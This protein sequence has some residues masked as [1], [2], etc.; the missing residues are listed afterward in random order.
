[1]EK[2]SCINNYAGDRQSYFGKRD[3][4]CYVSVDTVAYVNVSHPQAHYGCTAL[5]I[6][7][8]H[9]Q[10]LLSLPCNQLSVKP[11]RKF[12]LVCE[13]KRKEEKPKPIIAPISNSKDEIGVCENGWVYIDGGCY[14][15]IPSPQVVVSDYYDIC[16]GRLAPSLRE[17]SIVLQYAIQW[18]STFI[19]S[20]IIGDPEFRFCNNVT[21]ITMNP[22]NRNYING[23]GRIDCVAPSNFNDSLRLLCYAEPN[24]ITKN[25]CGPGMFQCHG[26]S[27]ILDVL[28]CDGT[29]NCPH[30]EDEM[31]DCQPRN[32]SY[33]VRNDVV[34]FQMFTEKCVPPYIMCPSE[35]CIHTGQVCDGHRDCSDGSDEMA[36]YQLEKAN[37]SLLDHE[38]PN[39]NNQVKPEILRLPERVRYCHDHGQAA[40]R[41][42][43]TQCYPYHRLC[44]FDRSHSALLYCHDGGHLHND[45]CS[46]H[47]C[48]EAF[49]CPG[50]YCVPHHRVC[51]GFPDC[52]GQ[53]DETQCGVRKFRPCPGLLRCQGEER[54][55]HP[56]YYN[57]G[58]KQCKYGDD[59]AVTFVCPVGCQCFTKGVFCDNTPSEELLRIKPSPPVLSLKST[60]LTL[61]NV[62]YH[63][64]ERTSRLVLSGGSLDRL[65]QP[66]FL[67]HLVILDLSNNSLHYV[68]R[69]FFLYLP[70]LFLLNLADNQL[71]KMNSL[72]HVCQLTY[73]NLRS[74]KLNYFESHCACSLS[75]VK[76]VDVVRN[77]IAYINLLSSNIS[78]HVVTDKPE[79]C[80]QL[81]VVSNCYW[82]GM[83]ASVEACTYLLG[84]IFTRIVV[85][86]CAIVGT[87]SNAYV[88]YW[89]VRYKI[90][91][92]ITRLQIVFLSAANLLIEAY[93]IILIVQ[94][95]NSANLF[96]FNEIGW[97]NGIWCHLG[98]FLLYFGF[99]TTVVVK[100][101]IVLDR[102]ILLRHAVRRI[103]FSK[104]QNI[105]ALVSSV[106]AICAVIM[107]QFILIFTEIYRDINAEY[108]SMVCIPFLFINRNTLAIA[109]HGALF[110]F[111]N[112]VLFTGTAVCYGLSMCKVLKSTDKA[113]AM[114]TLTDIG[115]QGRTNKMLAKSTIGLLLSVAGWLVICLM[116][117][118]MVS[119]D[120]VSV[121]YMSRETYEYLALILLL[122]NP[123]AD[124]IIFT[125]S[126]NNY[127][128]WLSLKS[129]K[130]N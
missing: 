19:F 78:Q 62:F 106:I 12:P 77:P 17:F 29:S 114:G 24:P 43:H 122:V 37:D 1:M 72:C 56:Y 57:D 2:K 75:K 81:P 16:G 76:L 9:T 91:S 121:G 100:F 13:Y 64:F 80:C 23:T 89:R 59:E 128:S 10:H 119:G 74:N 98:G 107:T 14:R 58:I 118:I 28:V 86:S 36:C 22:V 125:I 52:P 94:D 113:R 34:F 123:I 40:C 129:I 41:P 130:R 31:D 104:S 35:E 96:R 79:V 26:G 87:L 20:V 93:A 49:K 97:K 27:C 120:T 54:C 73:L 82:P 8:L 5:Y 70:N 21:V 39:I 95:L 110:M 84:N 117:I 101:I 15:L 50:T 124:P 102:V 47:Q 92:P 3:S 85:Y 66:P 18:A 127:I 67:P 109:Y 44:M 105:V 48:P 53:E 45:I 99:Q 63:V 68:N 116:E 108:G 32:T 7:D 51:D 103:G 30:S 90:G 126:S 115:R 61:T 33:T 65:P 88:L 69:N 55:V 71:T 25:N 42:D 83:V 38:R 11:D 6:T 46:Y 4:F 60:T 111:S 112:S